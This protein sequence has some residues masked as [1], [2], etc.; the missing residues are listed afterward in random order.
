MG[1]AQASGQLHRVGP[2]PL[3]HADEDPH[4]PGQHP[5]DP[6][7]DAPPGPKGAPAQCQALVKTGRPQGVHQGKDVVGAAVAGQLRHQ[8]RGEGVFRPREQGQFFQLL[9]NSARLSPTI[10]TRRWAAARARFFP[11]CRASRVSH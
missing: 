8:G 5:R 3:F 4:L 6:R 7:P 11:R 10:S 1:H 2:R 9:L